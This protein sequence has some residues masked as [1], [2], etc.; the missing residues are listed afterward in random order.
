[1]C[2]K[3]FNVQKCVQECKSVHKCKKCENV[4]KCASEQKCVSLQDCAQIAEK[5]MSKCWMFKCAKMC[6]SVKNVQM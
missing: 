1:M 2:A 3:V 6:E 5:N 4:Q